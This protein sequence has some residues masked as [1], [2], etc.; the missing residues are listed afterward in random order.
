MTKSIKGRWEEH[1]AVS[2]IDTWPNREKSLAIMMF[3]AGFAAA[4]EMMTGE[5]ADLPEPEAMHVLSE[6]EREIAQIEA[7]A[8]RVL[9]EIKPN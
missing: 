3:Y 9:G 1:A 8:S 5:V 7:L 4:F 6:I 2:G